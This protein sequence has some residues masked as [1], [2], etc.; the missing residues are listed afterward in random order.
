MKEKESLAKREQDLHEQDKVTS[1]ELDAASELLNTTYE[2][3]DEV[4]FFVS[5]DKSSIWVGKMM[6]EKANT[7]YVEALKKLD[8]IREKQ[9][10]IGTTSQT[11]HI[12]KKF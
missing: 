11:F 6:L 12:F 2:K 7:A 5:V 1:G 8:K 4:L 10:K 9:K 3:T